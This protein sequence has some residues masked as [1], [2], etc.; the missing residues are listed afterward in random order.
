M[1][2]LTSDNKM[3]LSRLETYN[4]NFLNI[5]DQENKLNLKLDEINKRI[6]ESENRLYLLEL[7]NFGNVNENNN[8]E[9]VKENQ[10]PIIEKKDNKLEEVKINEN[11]RSNIEIN[12]N[13][14]YSNENQ[15]NIDLNLNR[16]KDD[17]LMEKIMK[18]E[19]NN[20]K[21][22]GSFELNKDDKSY[23]DISIS[24]LIKPILDD[25]KNSKNNSKLKDQSNNKINDTDNY[26]DFDDI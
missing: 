10:S 26:D 22:V 1:E 6:K 23:K 11:S 9:E 17:E 3:L 4:D 7:K 25:D 12:M 8:K 15:N 16:N 21:E 5:N 19:K 2:N 14:I 13:N 20:Y 24:N 18:E